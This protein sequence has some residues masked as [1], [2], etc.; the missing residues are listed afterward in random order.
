[1]QAIGYRSELAKE[2]DDVYLHLQFPKHFHADIHVSW[3]SPLKERKIVVGG[4]KASLVVDE[5][6]GGDV[7]LYE[8]MAAADLVEG[9]LVH[10]HDTEEPLFNVVTH[11]LECIRNHNKPLSDGA[12]G[13]SVVRVLEAAQKSL[14][15]KG[16]IIHMEHNG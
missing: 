6:K 7:L 12:A 10:Q 14:D 1:M 13:G 15:L 3:C 8:K 4:S 2:E 9:V 16:A 5:D 11:F